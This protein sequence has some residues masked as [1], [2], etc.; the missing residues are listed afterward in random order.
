MDEARTEQDILQCSVM[1]LA[2]GFH[3]S[4]AEINISE[5]DEFGN[6]GSVLGQDL[7]AA[8]K[9]EVGSMQVRDADGTVPGLHICP[10]STMYLHSIMVHGLASHV[11]W[12]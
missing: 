10:Y 9:G 11:N 4:A 7:D 12:W 3:I 8:N 5:A 6:F 1:K 2:G